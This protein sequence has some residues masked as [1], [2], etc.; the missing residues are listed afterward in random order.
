M[1]AVIRPWTAVPVQG[2]MAGYDRPV[3]WDVYTSTTR[4][5]VFMD[6]KPSAFTLP[7]ACTLAAALGKQ[8]QLLV[9]PDRAWGGTN[10]AGKFANPKRLS[11][12]GGGGV[13]GGGG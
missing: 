1:P 4:V 7:E 3:Q 6:G 8:A 5:Y 12:G 13:A 2:D 10:S 9:V 11:A